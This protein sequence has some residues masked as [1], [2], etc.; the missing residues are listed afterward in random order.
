MGKG[1][2]K[3]LGW[4]AE[5]IESLVTQPRRVRAV[6]DILT[7][8]EQGDLKLRVR[9]LESERAFQRMDLI[10]SSIIAKAV[11]AILCLNTSLFL[12]ASNTASVATSALI[13]SSSGVAS[14]GGSWWSKIFSKLCLGGAMLFGLQIPLG[15]LKLKSFD[16]K[17]EELGFSG[18]KA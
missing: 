8:A 14:V 17:S 18:I 10:N 13:A 4:R 16:K 5:D 15:F 2:Q 1:W 9:V 3:K 6:S 7:R 11:L 12:Q